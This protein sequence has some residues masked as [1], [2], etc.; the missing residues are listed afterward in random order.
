MNPKDSLEKEILNQNT[1]LTKELFFVLLA[2]ALLPV[3]ILSLSFPP[4]IPSQGIAH[5][6]F[7]IHVPIAWVALYAPLLA[8]FSGIFYL[9]T[10]KEKYDIFSL[11]LIRTSCIFGLL[12]V[13]SGPLWAHTE[14]GSYWNWK[15]PRLVSFFVLLLSLVTCLLVRSLTDSLSRQKSASAVTSIFSAITAVLVWFAV[16]WIE[17]DTHPGPVLDSM[18]PKIHLTFWL[19]VLGYHLF[20]WAFLRMAVRHEQISRF[21]L[22]WASVGERE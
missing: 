16:R 5:R 22:M 13:V 7:Y 17:P 11:G 1:S 6:I 2:L 12:V 8:A 19:S 15:D 3:T 9:L 10:G 20:F 4:V 21:C 14:W 18:S